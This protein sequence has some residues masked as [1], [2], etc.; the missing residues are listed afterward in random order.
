MCIHR[1]LVTSGPPVLVKIKQVSNNTLLFLLCFY[2]FLQKM[3]EK[4]ID[5]FRGEIERDN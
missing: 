2:Q 3:L 5:L 4:S 1:H